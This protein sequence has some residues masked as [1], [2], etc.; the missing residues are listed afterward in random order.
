MQAQID[1]ALFQQISINNKV[2]SK[3]M[4]Q[5]KSSERSLM[6]ENLTAD[7]ER[8]GAEAYEGIQKIGQSFES[9]Q[10]PISSSLQ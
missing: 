8:F 3:S 10:V 2:E 4:I 6:L 7:I 5:Q 1:E 9:K